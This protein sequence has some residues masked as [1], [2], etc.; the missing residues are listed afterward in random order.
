MKTLG[1]VCLST[2]CYFVCRE[3]Q[4]Y[5]PHTRV[6]IKGEWAGQNKFARIPLIYLGAVNIFIIVIYWVF[7]FSSM[8][9]GSS[10]QCMAVEA[11]KTRGCLINNPCIAWD[12]VQ[13]IWKFNKV[14]ANYANQL[15]INH[16]LSPLLV[17]NW[18]KFYNLQKI[19]L[20]LIK[21]E[22]GS[23]PSK[24]YPTKYTAL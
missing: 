16:S 18:N 12:V 14:Q 17:I 4:K 24:C 13:L 22:G 21:G 9:F 5:Q 3:G 1:W 8:L 20:S 11:S 7:I 2:W 10:S 23:E 6:G 19:S 15:I